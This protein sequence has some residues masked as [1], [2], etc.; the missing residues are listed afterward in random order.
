MNTLPQK[1]KAWRARKKLSQPEAATLLNI[2]K[3]TL[4]GWE[5][6]R[7]SPSPLAKVALE[8]IFESK[9]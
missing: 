5:Q 1:L 8:L 9:P 7:H 3:G 4:Q 2:P 6:G